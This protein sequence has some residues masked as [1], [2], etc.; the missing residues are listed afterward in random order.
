M[1]GGMGRGVGERTDRG[2]QAI[3][4]ARALVDGSVG[5]STTVLVDHGRIV[6]VDA[7]GAAPPDHARLVDLG[8]VTLLPGLV[9][10]HLHL[11]FDASH[12]V[13]TPMLELDDATL[14]DRMHEHAR[15]NLAAG[16]TTIR[17]L[18]DRRF[19]SV[20]LRDRYRNDPASGPELLV[21]GPPITRRKGHCWFLGGEA[22][23]VDELRAAVG[24]RS[25]RGCDV[26]KVMATGGVITP[27]YLPHESQYSTTELAAIVAAARE[28]NLLTAAHAHGPEGI[29][30][31]ITAGVGSI[32][33][34]S[35]FTEEGVEADWQA[36]EQ[37]AARG[38][39]AG[40]TLATLPAST[41]PPAIAQR[42]EAMGS[43]IARMH[44]LGVPLVCSSDAGV[45]PPKPHGVLAHGVV[46][47]AGLGITNEQALAAATSV[48]AAA[49]GIGDRKGTIAPG[50][51]A[52]LL[53]VRGNP[54][55]D[56]TALLDVA[57]VFRGGV[58]VN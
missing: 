21:S 15:A 44:E 6:D 57:A 51:D 23:T 34:C 1:G 53:A 39:F 58:Q 14:L 56:I 26:V 29:R 5:G 28:T 2:M 55:D 7:T 12:D 52:D 50:F 45:A 19:L 32:E 43:N 25:D 35:F 42:I 30:A 3:R 48:A 17:D 36:A 38:I 8:D 4:A 37:L 33:H 40:V 24:E 10:A 31:S 20:E 18:G 46:A 13:L 27:G 49:C 9:D 47:L 11:C 41:P 54:I 16:V 22:D